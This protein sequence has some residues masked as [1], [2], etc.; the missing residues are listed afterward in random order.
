MQELTTERDRFIEAIA[1][2]TGVTRVL[3]SG[4][5]KREKDIEELTRR[6]F[7]AQALVQPLLIPRAP[8]VEDYITGPVSMFEDDFAQNKQFVDKVLEGILVSGCYRRQWRP[9]VDEFRTAVVQLAG[10]A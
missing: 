1:Y 3:V 10:A 8:A 5:E 9:Y 7:E 6:M 4:V 2:G